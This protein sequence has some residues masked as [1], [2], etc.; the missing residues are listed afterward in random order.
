[1]TLSLDRETYGSTTTLGLLPSTNIGTLVDQ[2]VTS[3]SNIEEIASLATARCISILDRS[4]DLRCAAKCIV[5]ARLFRKGASPYAPDL[6]IVNE[7]IKEAFIEACFEYTNSLDNEEVQLGPSSH[8]DSIEK[9]LKL[10]E[11]KGQII[12]QSVN[13]G[14]TLATVIDK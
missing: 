8:D 12:V 6:V 2:T 10:G 4:A 3:T 9:L 7:F 13:A 5:D 14:L 11:A 1:M